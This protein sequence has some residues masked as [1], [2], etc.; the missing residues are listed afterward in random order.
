MQ[1]EKFYNLHKIAFFTLA[2]FTF[3]MEKTFS[4]H[5]SAVQKRYFFRVQNE[6]IFFL[7][8]FLSSNMFS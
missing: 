6:C 3:K 5:I 8:I 2:R 1:H 7:F 4:Y